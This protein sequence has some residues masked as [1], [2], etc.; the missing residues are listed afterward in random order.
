MHCLGLGREPGALRVGVRPWRGC[1]DETLSL[2]PLLYPQGQ[3]L[4]QIV[5]SVAK[6]MKA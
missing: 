2:D 6:S 1:G 4:M 5:G 3:G